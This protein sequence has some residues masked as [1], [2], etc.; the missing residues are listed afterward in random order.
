[1]SVGEIIVVVVC[2]LFVAFVF[3]KGI[4]DK[5]NGK[6]CC[7]DCSSCSS[8]NIKIKEKEMEKYLKCESCGAIVKVIKPCNCKDCGIQ[9]CGNKMVEIPNPNIK[10]TGKILTCSSCGA[11]V[12]VIKPCN[13]PNCGIQCCGKEMK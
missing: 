6:T 3:I 10:G 8:C 1:M 7:G 2:V 9:C 13:C 4:I 5:R 11:Q 12:E